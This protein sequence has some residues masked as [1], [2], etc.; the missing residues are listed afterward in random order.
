[1]RHQ[2]PISAL[3]LTLGLTVSLLG[4]GG[5]GGSNDSGSPSPLTSVPTGSYGGTNIG[6][7]VTA[8]GG[9]LTLPC[10]ST[11]AIAAPVALDTTGHFSASGTITPARTGAQPVGLGPK[12]YA[13]TFTGTTDGTTINLTITPATSTGLPATTSVL[14]YNAAPV[15]NELCPG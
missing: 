8:A 13:A 14:T 4:C 5:G 2:F 6:L 3:I 9:T 1:M 10:G 15:F 12:P 7:A 11:G